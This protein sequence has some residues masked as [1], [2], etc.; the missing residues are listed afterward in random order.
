MISIVP[1]YPFSV[2]RPPISPI[3]E[4]T[5]ASTY[6][7]ALLYLDNVLKRSIP[8]EKRDLDLPMI[9]RLVYHERMVSR[10]PFDYLVNGTGSS[11]IEYHIVRRIFDIAIGSSLVAIPRVIYKTPEAIGLVFGIALSLLVAIVFR[12]ASGNAKTSSIVMETIRTEQ[13]PELSSIVKD[14]FRAIPLAGHFLGKAYDIGGILA[15]DA[16]DAIYTKIKMDSP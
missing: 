1:E 14:V 4:K 6:E 11:G 13:L 15:E 8:E 7:R 5:D 10:A 9:D 12:I 3:K 16:I 2:E